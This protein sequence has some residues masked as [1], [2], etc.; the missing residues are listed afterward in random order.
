MPTQ[1]VLAAGA[2]P[3]SRLED[4]MRATL[5]LIN[6]PDL[7]RVSGRYFDGLREAAP[8]AQAHDAEARRRLRDLSDRLVGL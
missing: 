1:M 6:D 4:G 5:R 7:D 8:H 2:T 3:V